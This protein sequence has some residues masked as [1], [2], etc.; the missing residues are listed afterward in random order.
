[1]C[2]NVLPQ[3]FVGHRIA[4]TYRFDRQKGLRELWHRAMILPTSDSVWIT[5]QWLRPVVDWQS[6][7]IHV[8][9]SH[10]ILYS[11]RYNQM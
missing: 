4:R 5:P 8:L 6:Q 2:L 10:Q 3:P 9:W 11:F 1:M 7:K